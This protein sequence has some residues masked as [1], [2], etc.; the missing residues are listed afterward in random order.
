MQ[1]LMKIGEAARLS[2]V[3]VRTVHYYE[4][5]GLLE[6][7]ARTDA[8]YR[9]YGQEEVAQLRFIQRAKLLGLTLEEIRGLVS[10]AAGCNRG[11]IIPHLQKLLQ[12]KVEETERRMEE[13]GAFR[14]NLLYYQRRISGTDPERSCGAEASFCGC[15]ES[16]TAKG[17]KQ[18]QVDGDRKRERS[19]V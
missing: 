19:V 8:G 18:G 1:Q 2:G 5:R 4:G 9:L 16:V 13:L 17:E 12:E 7:A 10:A 11:E 6:P 14:E 3:A 15:L